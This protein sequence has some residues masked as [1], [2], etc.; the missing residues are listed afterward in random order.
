MQITKSSLTRSNRTNALHSVSIACSVSTFAHHR[1]QLLRDNFNG[2]F[3]KYT[4]ICSS[5]NCLLHAFSHMNPSS[6]LKKNYRNETRIR[7][8]VA[9]SLTCPKCWRHNDNHFSHSLRSLGRFRHSL[10][11]RILFH[12]NS[13]HILS[14]R[15]KFHANGNVCFMSGKK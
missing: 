3:V 1:K 14:E 7:I 4:H 11:G 12:A 5:S 10:N 2:I 6:F 8:A 15:L 9:M 13:T